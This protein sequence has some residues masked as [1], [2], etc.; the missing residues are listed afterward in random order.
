LLSV[1]TFGSLIGEWVFR[2]GQ[3]RRVDFADDQCSAVQAP[4][5]GYPTHGA[6]YR[7]AASVDAVLAIR[8]PF[9]AINAKDDPVS[10]RILLRP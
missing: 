8:I 1:N 5:W 10:L 6:Y 9:L 7:D 3:R 2:V 4:T